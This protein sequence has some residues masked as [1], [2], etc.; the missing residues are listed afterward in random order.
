MLKE[1][2]EEFLFGDGGTAPAEY[3]PE[4][5][6]QAPRPTEL[7]L[8]ARSLPRLAARVP[9][10]PLGDVADAARRARVDGRTLW[11]KREGASSPRY[12]GNKVRTLEAWLGHA[13]ERRRASGSGR[14]ARTARTTRSRPCCTRARSGSTPARSCSRS[15]RASGRSRT[16]AR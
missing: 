7:A 14:S 4:K 10:A 15:R 12:G 16:R 11:V 5:H 6:V 9:W 3:V 2:C 13:R 1:Q 8:L